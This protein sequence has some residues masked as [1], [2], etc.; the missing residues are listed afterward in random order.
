MRKTML[1]ILLAA[2]G[3]KAPAARTPIAAAP[4]AQPV[5]SSATCDDLGCT[6]TSGEMEG[7]FGYG[8]SGVGPGPTSGETLG[9][10]G[11]YDR[12]AHGAGPGTG[13][14]H[15][16]SGP[17]VAVGDLAV[18]GSGLAPEAIRRYLRQH[19]PGFRDCDAKRPTLAGT[20]DVHFVVG[21]DGSVT[22]ASVTA[23]LDLAVDGCVLDEIK[24]IQFPSPTN[25][26]AVDVTSFPLHLAP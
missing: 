5:S 25:G 24:R 4:A 22:Q 6:G 8:K 2:C 18:T 20:I 16:T 26:A 12:I 14:E 21:A 23:G 11:T 1:A 15:G 3:A 7:G 19:L 10:G 17:R 9:L 13:G